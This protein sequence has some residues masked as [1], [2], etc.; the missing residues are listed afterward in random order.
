MARVARSRKAGLQPIS[1]LSIFLEGF[2]QALQVLNYSESTVRN[3]RVHIGYF[4]RWCHD[5]GLMEPAKVTRPILEDYQRYLFHYRKKN[6]KPLTSRSQAALLVPLRTW[7]K[8]MARNR[9]IPVNPAAE[10]EL[11]RQEH[12]LPKTILSVSEIEQV[13]ARPDITD[14]LGLRDR[15]LM[16][17]LYSTGMRRM[18]LANL[19]IHDLD[20]ERGTV[21][22]RKGKGKKDR[23]IPIGNRA[24]AWIIK[25]IH[26]S[27]PKLSVQPDDH[28]LFLSN[29]GESLSLDHLSDLVRAYIDSTNIGKRGACHMFRH[30]VATFMLDNGADIRFI[31]QMLGHADLKTTQIYTHISIRQLKRVH[32][33]THPAEL[34]QKPKV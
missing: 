8:W 15:A 2:L 25:Y 26:E 9:S 6:G 18:E 33:A 7:F 5:Q 1:Q 4:I 12:Q 11:P 29:A 13:L 27:R 19:K 21:M 22:I 28:T 30:C 34:G 3:R 14:P 24:V 17:A 32:A 20:T 10:L 23:V 31:Q 16:E